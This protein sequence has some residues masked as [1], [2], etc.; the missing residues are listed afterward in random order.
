MSL[1]YQVDL[2]IFVNNNLQC[3]FC[4]IWI[5]R[6]KLTLFSLGFTYL[7]ILQWNDKL[8]KSMHCPTMKKYSGDDPNVKFHSFAFI[9]ISE[10]ILRYSIFCSFPLIP[11]DRIRFPNWSQFVQYW[12]LTKFESPRPRQGHIKRAKMW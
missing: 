10:P 7:K 8:W 5:E 11:S 3:S 1:L 9:E 12:V 6:V 2:Y 4:Q